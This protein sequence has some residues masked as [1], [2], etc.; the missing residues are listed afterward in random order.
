VTNL[1]RE[2]CTKAFHDKKHRGQFAANTPLLITQDAA[3]FAINWLLPRGSSNLESP[4]RLAAPYGARLPASLGI[5]KGDPLS[6]A[7][8]R[9]HSSCTDDLNRLGYR[10]AN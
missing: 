8:C 2:H 5:A 6:R 4:P 7:C 1:S 10:L 9:K 3:G